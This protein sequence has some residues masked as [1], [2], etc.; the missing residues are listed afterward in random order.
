MD[1]NNPAFTRIWH[2]GK[3]RYRKQPYVPLSEREDWDGEV[4]VIPAKEDASFEFS[5][6]EM[7]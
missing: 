1:T 2:N 4:E 7:K 5:N 3:D 6:W